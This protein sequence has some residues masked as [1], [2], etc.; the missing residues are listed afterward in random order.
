MIDPAPRPRRWLVLA[1][2]AA[3]AGGCQRDDV[4]AR[5]PTTPGGGGQQLHSG[6]GP[7]A[8]ITLDLLRTWSEQLCTL[9]PLDFA[10]ALQ[11]L[12]I[13][14]SLVSKTRDYSI[15]DPPPAGTS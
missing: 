11:A 6:P 4:A 7:A 8:M 2:A 5:G 12:G 13:A 3:V 9:P 10:G 15:V 1:I 14:G